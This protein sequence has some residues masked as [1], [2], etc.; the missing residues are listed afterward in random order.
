MGSIAANLK[1]NVREAQNKR[2]Q[3]PDCGYSGQGGSGFF[4]ATI[5]PHGKGGRFNWDQGTNKADPIGPQADIP[6]NLPFKCRKFRVNSFQNSSDN[7]DRYISLAPT[8][9]GYTA[10]GSFVAPTPSGGENWFSLNGPNTGTPQ[11][12]IIFK[13][14]V[15][16]VY[17]TLGI[18][19]GSQYTL[20]LCCY[21][22]ALDDASVVGFNQH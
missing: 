12:V 9:I 22:D 13:E 10:G 14:P 5:Q 15:D 6:I 7:N 19:A 17:L 4:F 8:G 20:T 3:Q 16:L 1:D 11:P 2:T 21:N 18:N